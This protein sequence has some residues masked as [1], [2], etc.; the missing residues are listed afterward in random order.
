MWI[1]G[2]YNCNFN[3]TLLHAIYFGFYCIFACLF[4]LWIWFDIPVWF[5]RNMVYCSRNWR[6]FFVIMG[7]ICMLITINAR[8]YTQLLWMWFKFCRVI[9]GD[10]LLQKT[11]ARI[12]IFSNLAPQS[13]DRVIQIIGEPQ[14]CIDTI[15]EVLTLIKQVGELNNEKFY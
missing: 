7:K 2:V 5:Q 10:F 11:G 3:A 1:H 6:F 14:Q 4:L 13:T 12:K 8:Y 15:R 9:I